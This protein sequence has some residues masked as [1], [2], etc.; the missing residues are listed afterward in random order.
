MG[1]WACV[2][3]V[4]G[5]VCAGEVSVGCPAV[6]TAGAWVVFGLV[7]DGMVVAVFTG[8]GVVGDAVGGWGACVLVGVGVFGVEVGAVCP[9]RS[10]ID[11][12]FTLSPQ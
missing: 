12:I 6:V 10:A 5:G 8:L 1:C 7:G 3:G 2:W 4:G 9:S 11:I